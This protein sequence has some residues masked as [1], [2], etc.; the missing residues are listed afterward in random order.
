MVSDTCRSPGIQRGHGELTTG[1]AKLW[2]RLA[3]ELFG[4]A[5]ARQRSYA[6]DGMY[7]V[8]RVRQDFGG[9]ELR[10]V[11]WGCRSG[12]MRN[13]AVEAVGAP[14]SGGVLSLERSMKT[15]KPDTVP[16]HTWGVV[17]EQNQRS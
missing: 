7:K 9:W 5:Q 17:L 12:G 16:A 2:E 3:S 11:W 10:I 13:K 15:T 8:L 1:S 6:K 4:G 14:R